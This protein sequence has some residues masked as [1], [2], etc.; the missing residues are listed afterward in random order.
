MAAKLLQSADPIP[1]RPEIFIVEC[2]SPNV[3]IKLDGMPQANF[4]LFRAARDA[5]V[6]GKV[7]CDHRNFGM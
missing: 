3:L 1:Q 6:A 5:R 2:Q 4:R 7:E